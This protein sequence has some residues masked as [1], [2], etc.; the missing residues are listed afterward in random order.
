M[1]SAGDVEKYG[2]CPLTWWLSRGQVDE[3]TD[4]RKGA[5]RAALLAV[6]RGHEDPNVRS[7]TESVE[8]LHRTKD[9]GHSS[10]IIGRA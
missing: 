1:F 10:L 8:R 3:G 9:R 2:Y 4:D 6:H 5:E 7:H